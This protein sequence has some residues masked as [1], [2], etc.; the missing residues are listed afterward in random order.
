MTPNKQDSNNITDR[1]HWLDHFKQIKQTS[2]SNIVKLP[3]YKYS[4]IL[5]KILPKRDDWNVLEI[6]AFP[7]NNL[8]SMSIRY[9]YKPVAIDFIPRVHELTDSFKSFGIDDVEIIEQDFFNWKTNRKFNVV[10]SYGFVEHF[11]DLNKT[12]S[13]HWDL[14]AEGGFMIVT[15]PIFGP[16]QM[17]LRRL[18]LTEEKLK[19][20]L[21]T[22]NL[23]VMDVKKIDRLAS[24]FHSSHRIFSDH[25]REMHTWFKVTDSYV[26]KNRRII[27]YIWKII[28][29]I[30]FWLKWSN[31]IYSPTG[32][33]IYQKRIVDAK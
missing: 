8:A 25:I 15:I 28:A 7:G 11:T 9:G 1:R 18:I 5:D 12:L 29:K 20:I 21:E 6:G 24:T 19:N 16:L 32:M 4:N 33:V 14:V 26:R 30:P 10:M 2:T 27:L 23:S 31:R 13:R 22:H 3:S 17:L